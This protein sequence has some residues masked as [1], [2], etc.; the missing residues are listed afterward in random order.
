MSFITKKLLNLN[1]ING[2]QKFMDSAYLNDSTYLDYL[3]RMEQ[4]CESMFEWINLPES[5][6]SR[7][8]E[9]TL[10]YFGQA[11]ILK[12][13]Q[14]GIINTRCT[15]DD[16]LN[17]YYLPT[18]V[19]CYSLDFHKKRLVYSGFK[20]ETLNEDNQCILVMN[21]WNRIPTA[22]SIRLFAYRMYLASRSIDI[23]VMAT[24]TP[25][26]IL[27]TEKQKLTLNNLYNQYNGNQPFIFGDSDILSPEMLKAINT[28]APYVTDKLS[29]YKKEIWNEFL[30]FIGVNAIDVEKKERLIS[31]EANA[32]NESI[33]LNLQ[34]YLAPRQK[35]CKQFNDLFG[36]TGTDK[37]ISV[38]L[39][40]DLYNIIKQKES[41]VND[42]NQNGVPD[43]MEE[44]VV[45]E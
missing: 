34:A 28:Q 24:R 6:D 1:K 40:S 29:D 9:H 7:F 15:I 13:E 33:N 10:F 23:N 39:R 43:E 41:V 11:T 44:G 27:G 16:K 26:L 22:D 5:M 30:Q 38:R 35:A 3:N 31:G 18:A 8:L 36:L 45:N 21:N 2:S 17:I 37:E 25:I 42:Y 14:F 19:N 4:I 20:N 12:D 32:N